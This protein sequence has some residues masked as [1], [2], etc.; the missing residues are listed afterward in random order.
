[1]SLALFTRALGWSVD[2]LTIFLAQVR[3]DLKNRNYHAYWNFWA[4]YGRK[5]VDNK[6]DGEENQS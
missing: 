1:M 5:R 4:I 2:G 6:T 3:A